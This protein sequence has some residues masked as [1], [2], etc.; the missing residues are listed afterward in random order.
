MGGFGNTL[1]Q[2]YAAYLLEKRGYSVSLNTIMTER[3]VF[4]KLA[5]WKVHEVNYHDL[6]VDYEIRTNPFPLL[7]AGFRKATGISNL[8]TD[9]FL[10]KENVGANV[11]GY[12]QSPE[13]LG[14]DKQA[15]SEFGKSVFDRLSDN[16]SLIEGPAPCTVLHARFGDSRMAMSNID[17][18]K[19]AAERISNANAARAVTDSVSQLHEYLGHFNIQVDENCSVM[20]DFLTLCCAEVVVCAPSTFSWWACH[21]NANLKQAFLPRL[22]YDKLG[23]YRDDVE[24][25]VI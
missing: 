23:F 15:L 21:C 9:G 2:L 18:Y 25:V 12:F 17:Y 14:A 3:N 1:F 16:G 8:V 6:I 5:R 24:L 20:E 13:F 19:K 7:L 10:G 11:F 22:I 4:T